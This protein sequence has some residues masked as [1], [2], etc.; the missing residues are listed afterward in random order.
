M[1]ENDKDDK[2]ISKEL[3][4][5]TIEDDCKKRNIKSAPSGRKLFFTFQPS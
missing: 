3:L 4:S 2:F 1:F 5:P